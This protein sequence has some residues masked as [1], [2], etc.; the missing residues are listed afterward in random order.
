MVRVV[1]SL[2]KNLEYAL[3]DVTKPETLGAAGE[4]ERQ[5]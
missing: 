3:G 2:A 1:Q 5:Q 4:L